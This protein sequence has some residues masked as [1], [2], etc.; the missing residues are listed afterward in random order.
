MGNC[1]GTGGEASGGGI[2]LGSSEN[3]DQ[4]HHHSA[5]PQ[6]S[7]DA[8]GERQRALDAAEER[9]QVG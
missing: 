2:R 3:L 1:C 8:A 7:L 9:R 6:M 5:R 4:E